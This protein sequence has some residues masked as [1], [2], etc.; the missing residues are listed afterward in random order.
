MGSGSSSSKTEAPREI[1]GVIDVGESKKKVVQFI[2]LL[3]QQLLTATNPIN[4]KQALEASGTG[5]CSGILVLLEPTIATEFQRLSFMDPETKQIVK[6][7]FKGYDSVEDLSSTVITKTMCKEITLFFLR[8]LI[9]VGTCVLSVRPNKALTGLLGTLGSTMVEGSKAF[10]GIVKLKFQGLKSG[11]TKAAEGAERKDDAKPNSTETI[12]SK[13][14]EDPKDLTLKVTIKMILN[15]NDK[16]SVVKRKEGDYF[17]VIYKAK[18]YVLDLYNLVLYTNETDTAK[19]VGVISISG[20]FNDP[21]EKKEE[22]KK[23]GTRSHRK[24]Q[25]RYT[26]KMR[27]GDIV[28]KETSITKAEH[29]AEDRKQYYYMFNRTDA[30]C[31]NAKPVRAACSSSEEKKLTSNVQADEFVKEIVEYYLSQFNGTAFSKEQIDKYGAKIE[32]I[33]GTGAKITGYVPLTLEDK[34]TYARLQ[35][36]LESGEV[37][38]LEEG[39]CFAV[40]RAYLL[41]SGV[42]KTEKGPELKTYI[43]HDKWAETSAKLS[44]LPLF[45]LLEQL[46]KDRLGNTM[47]PATAEKYNTFI[48]K[49]SS[50]GTLEIDEKGK[51]SSFNNLKFKSKLCKKVLPGFDEIKDDPST[52]NEVLTQYKLIAASLV[53]LIEDITKLLDKIIDFPLF[54]KE[55]RIKLRPVFV[56][57]TRGAQSVLTGFIE[58][59]RTLLENHILDVEQAYLEGVTT[60][61]N[62][63][64]SLL[65]NPTLLEDPSI[66]TVL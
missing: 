43:C 40:Y 47:E 33:S 14:N 50:I 57:D 31:N 49:L 18:E 30:S 7:I 2:D 42:I 16:Y 65:S 37:G 25:E 34:G 15:N 46:Y 28:L 62:Y 8:L 24:R 29:L 10:Q 13:L 22:P 52:V 11:A 64:E 63:T 4:F 12:F 44:S 48:N 6:S 39:P 27:G 41:A 60:I 3:F 61:L 38:K 54:T 1:G 36:L 32:P 23:G 51:E 21:P 66:K 17:V 26:R 5:S 20:S 35:N 53:K 9:L 56:T 59:A 45:S 58:E 55:N 19:T